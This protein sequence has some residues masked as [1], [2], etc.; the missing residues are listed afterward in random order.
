[1]HVSRTSENVTSFN[2]LSNFKSRNST[3]AAIQK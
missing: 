2:K 3:I 1:M